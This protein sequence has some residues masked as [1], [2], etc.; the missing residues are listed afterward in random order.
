MSLNLWRDPLPARLNWD[1]VDGFLQLK[2]REGPQLEYR[3]RLDSE[4]RQGQARRAHGRLP[5]VVG[6]MANGSGGLILIG[7]EADDHDAP[8][9]WPTVRPGQIK[10]Q[11]I[12]SQVRNFVEPFVPVEVGVASS[13]NGTGD[14]VVVRVPEG[15]S[16]PVFVADR[17]ILIR[18]GEASVPASVAAIRSWLSDER[19]LPNQLVVDFG[20]Y[21]SSNVQS[22]PP[23]VNIGAYPSKR[24]YA[25]AWNDASDEDITGIVKRAYPGLSLRTI[26]DDLLDFRLPDEADAVTD[27]IWFKPTG[28][29]LRRRLIDVTADDRVRVSDLAADIGR[30]WLIAQE[31]IPTLAPGYVGPIAIGLAIGTVKAGFSSRDLG[32]G[33]LDAV[34]HRPRDRRVAWAKW[35]EF[36]IGDDPDH[37]VIS[38]IAGLLRGFGYSSVGSI[39]RRVTD[40]EPWIQAL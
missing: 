12:E 39:L 23:V 30:T 6:A 33:S 4:P 16:K 17:G 38:I 13:P 3:S 37:V 5:D 27:W 36:D 21:I 2:V 8:T 40:A 31:A 10:P 26:S 1:D 32:D 25:T 20:H 34:E 15:A 11:A 28:S 9:R 14:V 35:A 29:I 19:V 7:V 22:E 18:E 24:W